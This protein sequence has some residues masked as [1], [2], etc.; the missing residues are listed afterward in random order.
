M[1]YLIVTIFMLPLLFNAQARAET[2]LSPAQKQQIESMIADYFIQNPEALGS[3]L[4]NMQAHYQRLETERRQK[5]VRDNAK[6]LFKGVGDFSMGPKDAPITIVEFFDYNCGYCKQVFE[7]LMQVLQ[8]NDDVRL[9]FKEMPILNATSTEAA[10]TAL[11]I[12]DQLKFLTFHTKLMTHRGSINSALI[13]RTL[14]ELKLSPAAI[15]KAAQDPEIAD[16][17]NRNQ[18]L[19]SQLG[20]TGTPAFIINDEIH[21][22]ALDKESLDEIIM[23]L[24]EKLANNKG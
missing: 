5:A 2:T 19:A 20:I 1:R 12:D 24:R 10:Q 7:P 21:A 23:R 14:E 22:G 18:R 13:E 4:D 16:I 3:A 8:E 15:R 11:A 17:I 9:V 6:D